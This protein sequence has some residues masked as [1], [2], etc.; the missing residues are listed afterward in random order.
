VTTLALRGLAVR[1]GATTVVGPVDLDV[2]SG[3]ILALLGPSGC[4][5]TTLLSAIARLHELD[6]AGIVTGRVELGGVNVA[7]V[8]VD[9]HRRQV[10]T[11][12]QHPVLFPMSIWENVAFA[13]R[14]HGCARSEVDDRVER[15][16]RAAA[17]WDEVAD[18]RHAD[19][20]TLSG[21]QQQRLCLARALA[22][23]PRVLLLDEPCS[24][25]DPGSTALVEQAL[26]ALTQTTLVLVTHN[27]AQVR[28]IATQCA[29]LWAGPGGGRLVDVG[30]TERV[31]AAPA[32]PALAAWFS[33]AIG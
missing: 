17:L 20:T 4:G 6:D 11:L 19:P 15:A 27:L 9:T 7:T 33:G 13:L 32:S 1:Y 10:G 23:E 12:L 21:G 28:R 18:R 30:P 14:R 8:P 22:L 29:C 2:A 24:A 31:F 26:V 25:L 3:E 5:K 16:L